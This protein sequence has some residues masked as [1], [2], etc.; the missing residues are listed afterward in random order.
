MDVAHNPEK[1]AAVV[2]TFKEL[3]P[4][5]EPA[6]VFS[7]KWTKDVRLMART[8]HAIAH[9]VVLTHYV[10]F[11]DNLVNR[12]M[13]KPQLVAAFEEAGFEKILWEDR[14]AGAL[15]KALIGSTKFIIAT[16]S[17]HLL[18]ELYER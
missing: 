9:T 5:E 12:V 2:S 15:Q 8:L 17:F 11:S 13:G 1:I 16:G 3:W 14:P 7:C 6:V 4:G 18:R 10:P